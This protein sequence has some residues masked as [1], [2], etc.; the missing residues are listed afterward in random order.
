MVL[1]HLLFLLLFS[2]FEEEM[3]ENFKEDQDIKKLKIRY[4]NF[5]VKD[6]E[7]FLYQDSKSKKCGEGV[8]RIQEFVKTD[9]TQ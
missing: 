4:D 7:L 8:R 3:N 5:V 9:T 1:T 6:D 2:G